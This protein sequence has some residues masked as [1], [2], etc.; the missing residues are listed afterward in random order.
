M[1]CPVLL[2]SGNPVLLYPG[3]L[4][5][6]SLQI[7]SPPRCPSVP[8]G[9]ICFQRFLELVLLRPVESAL[10]AYE[11]RDVFVLHFCLERLASG[12]QVRRFNV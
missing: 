6:Y 3:S 5:R 12:S 9:S 2:Y 7:H 8:L 4:N 1:D 10:T 11:G